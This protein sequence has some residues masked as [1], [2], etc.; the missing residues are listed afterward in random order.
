MKKLGVL[1]LAVPL[2]SYV[3]ESVAVYAKA[4]RYGMALCMA[5]YAL[6]NVGL[7]LDLYGI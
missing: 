2:L 6:A 5:A 4:G 1:F 7:I 3:I